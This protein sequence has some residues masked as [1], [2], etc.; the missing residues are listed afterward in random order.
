MAD[1]LRDRLTAFRAF[2]DSIL[3]DLDRLSAEQR[4]LIRRVLDRV[5]RAG[6]DAAHH[7]LREY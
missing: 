1:D 7:A 6:I 2:A 3:A 4:E 5:D